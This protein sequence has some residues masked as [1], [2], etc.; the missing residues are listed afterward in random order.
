MNGENEYER[1]KKLGYTEEQIEVVLG[2]I[3]KLELND[4][5]RK[6]VV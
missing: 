4:S 1:L 6:S 3:S 5:D 2:P